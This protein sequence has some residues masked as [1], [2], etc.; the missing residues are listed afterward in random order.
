MYLT[1]LHD[2]G[3]HIKITRLDRSSYDLDKL[4]LNTKLEWELSDLA[5]M[6]LLLLLYVKKLNTIVYF[7]W[8]NRYVCNKNNMA[9]MYPN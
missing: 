3:C 4:R 7:V 5:S 8:V 1:E 6:I 2:L 9:Y